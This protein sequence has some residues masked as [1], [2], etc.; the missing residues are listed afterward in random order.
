MKSFIEI[1]KTYSSESDPQGEG[2]TDKDTIHSYGLTYQEL[3]EP[4]RDSVRTVLE[5]GVYKGGSVN[6][7]HDYFHNAIIYGIDTN[8]SCTKYEK[9]RIRIVVGNASKPDILEHVPDN[10]DL[11][12]DDGS[13]E[14]DDVASTLELFY[15]RLHDNGLYI[16]EDVQNLSLWIRRLSSREHMPQIIDLRRIK[17]RYDDILLIF[18][19][20]HKSNT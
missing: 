6:L 1:L 15:N 14:I 17:N 13:H 12:I 2:F 5:I 18:S 9:D 19:K 8:R 4:I 20:Q 7:Y 3:F 16:V 11:V 10:I